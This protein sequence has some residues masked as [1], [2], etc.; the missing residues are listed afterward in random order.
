[1]ILNK[2]LSE[3]KVNSASEIN[4]A[5]RVISRQK[6]KDA[7]ENEDIH[8]IEADILR[9]KSGD[10]IMCHP[11]ENESDLT[12]SEFMHSIKNTHKGIKLDF[13]DPS[14]V[15]EC[16]SILNKSDLKMPILLNADILRGPGGNVPSFDA[17]TFVQ[18]ASTVPNAILS[19]GWTTKPVNGAQY[20]MEMVEEMTELTRDYPSHV[21][22]PV[23]IF[24]SQ[25]SLAALNK[26]IMDKERSLTWW[27]NE[28]VSEDL[29]NNLLSNTDRAR[30]FYDIT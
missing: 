6:L 15:A 18:Q 21:T 7:L 22:Y 25:N 20:T 26:L 4:W 17:G 2:L 3:L 1:M 16:L 28:P 9:G 5:H 11:P 12:Y 29:K 24:Y 13:K 8:C 14:V 27:N 19:V 30:C 23:R 10:I